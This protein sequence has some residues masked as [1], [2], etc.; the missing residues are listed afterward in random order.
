MFGD[1]AI[2]LAHRG[3]HREIEGA[4]GRAGA[5]GAYACATMEKPIKK[6]TVEQIK[7]RVLQ[8]VNGAV[9]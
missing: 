1:L 6:K 2:W 8:F 3:A 4:C 7:S 9:L 5:T